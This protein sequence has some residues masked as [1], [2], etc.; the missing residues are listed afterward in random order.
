M[1]ERSHGFYMLN[2]VAKVNPHFQFKK[3]QSL[4]SC[5]CSL[6]R[7][8]HA[9]CDLVLYLLSEHWNLSVIYDGTI[10]FQ[11]L[12]TVVVIQDSTLSE[13]GSKFIILKWVA[14]LWEEGVVNLT[15]DLLICLV[16]FGA[17]VF[18]FLLK[19]K[20]HDIH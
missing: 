12:I 14:T 1:C 2:T 18:R 9:I 6:Q 3:T 7:H 11:K 17:C 20:N 4:L 15:K 5:I 19:R 8:I 10:R 16:L 13:I